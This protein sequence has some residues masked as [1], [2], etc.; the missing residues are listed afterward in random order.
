MSAAK[1]LAKP[2]AY[3]RALS[4]DFEKSN[5]TNILVIIISFTTNIFILTALKNDY[6]HFIT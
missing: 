6:R 2:I 1:K 4:D 5:G 3:S